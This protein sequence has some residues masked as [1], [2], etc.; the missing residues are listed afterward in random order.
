MAN[1]PEAAYC[2]GL[3][4]LFFYT[5]LF[6]Y[7]CV[8]SPDIGDLFTIN[9]ELLPVA[10][11]WRIG[12]ALRLDPDRLDRIHQRNHVDVGDYLT[13]V[14]TEWL[15]KAYDVTRFGAPSWKLLVEA[16]AHRA[17]GNDRALA[18]RVAG[19]YKGIC[20][21]NY[22]SCMFHVYCPVFPAIVQLHVYVL[23]LRFSI[24]PFPPPH[25]PSPSVQCLC[26]EDV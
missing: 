22:M 8:H 13:D 6:D 10:H 2:T 7:S 26:R 17:G 21:C 9:S 25:P 11:K 1:K 18:E 3:H 12:L 4:L 23:L 5:T 14:L 20:I 19:K 24:T 16:V 15:K